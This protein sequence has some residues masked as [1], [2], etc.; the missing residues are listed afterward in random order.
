M[1]IVRA[2]IVRIPPILEH[3]PIHRRGRSRF[4]IHKSEVSIVQMPKRMIETLLH[5]NCGD[6]AR[7]QASDPVT[8]EVCEPLLEI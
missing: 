2:E 8:S 7:A 3:Y 1:D 5:P 4:P 6:F